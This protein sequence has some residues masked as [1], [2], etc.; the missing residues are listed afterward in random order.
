MQPDNDKRPAAIHAWWSDLQSDPGARARLRRCR[1]PIEALAQPATIELMLRMGWKPPELD[2]Y[3]WYG[4]RIAA[5]AMVLAHVREHSERPVARLLGATYGLDKPILSN[6]R[7]ERLSNAEGHEEIATQFTRVIQMLGGTAN[8][9]DL[10]FAMRTWDSDTNHRAKQRW[11]YAY[12]GV[13]MRPQE[14][15]TSAV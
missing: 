14:A 11:I 1:K 3:D 15:G 9:V 4:E 7:W 2:R 12:F 5:I 10:A 13:D 8:V 6:L